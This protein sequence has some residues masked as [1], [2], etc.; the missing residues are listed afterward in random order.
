MLLVVGLVPLCGL[1]LLGHWPAWEAGAGTA[2][3]LFAIHQLVRPG[4]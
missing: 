3:S 2:M 1:A 4:G